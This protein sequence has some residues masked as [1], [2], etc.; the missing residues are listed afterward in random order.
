MPEFCCGGENRGGRTSGG[1]KKKSTLGNVG[2]CEG[3][4]FLEEKRQAGIT[5]TEKTS[6]TNPLYCLLSCGL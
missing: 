4:R 3:G 1:K 5:K 2:A 6:H